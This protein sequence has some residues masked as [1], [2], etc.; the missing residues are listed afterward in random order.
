MEKKK[1]K[2][3]RLIALIFIS[4]VLC[5]AGSKK[6][7]G[8]LQCDEVI[9]IHD[10]DS[11]RC[12]INGVQPIIGKNI[13]IRVHGVDT[14]EMDGKSQREKDLALQAKKITV[15]FIESCPTKI[16][17]KNIQRGKYFRI[18]A[19][20]YCGDKLLSKELIDANLAYEYYGGKKKKWK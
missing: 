4:S 16:L 11:F 18:V 5:F 12:N 13:K 2:Y 6:T 10:G 7:F 19:D 1:S 17:L 9:S 15:N 14:P 20:V 3:T 8:D